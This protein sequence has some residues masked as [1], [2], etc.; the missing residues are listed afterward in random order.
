MG[1]AMVSEQNREAHQWISDRLP[2]GET[3]LW[4]GKPGLLRVA[5]QYQLVVAA[6]LVA[7]LFVLGLGSVLQPAGSEHIIAA[8]IRWFLDL[9]TGIL[10]LTLLLPAYRILMALWT[11]YA[12]TDKRVLILKRLSSRSVSAFTKPLH[13][14]RRDWVDLKGDLIFTNAPYKAWYFPQLHRQIMHEGFYGID[15]VGEV[16]R[17]I[18]HAL[19]GSTSKRNEPVRVKSSQ[20]TS[21]MDTY[22]RLWIEQ[23]LGQGEKVL[24]AS[25]PTP[26][27]L[28]LHALK[29]GIRMLGLCLLIV[30]FLGV[31][32]NDLVRS[33]IPSLNGITLMSILVWV[34]FFVAAVP[35]AAHELRQAARTVYAI[36]DQRVLIIRRLGSELEVAV[37]DYPLELE[38]RERL[39][40]TGGDLIF[41]NVIEDEFGMVLTREIV[42]AGLFGIKDVS[43]VERMILQTLRGSTRVTDAS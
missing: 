27:W 16:E 13:I 40:S 11:I 36:T 28:A 35:R 25:Q 38:R 42:Y 2:S 22:P 1:D 18:L 31:T 9:L 14:R 12:I 29:P 24:W 33:G 21:Q 34:L 37:Y 7:L 23:Q 8:Q 5:M 15:N 3:V 30:A 41:K 43:E 32:E 4:M 6:N 19:P 17:L 10:L 26:L 20:T 39:I